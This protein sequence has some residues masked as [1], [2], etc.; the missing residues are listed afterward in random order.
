MAPS[1]DCRKP[2]WNGQKDDWK[3]IQPVV[4]LSKTVYQKEFHCLEG[5]VAIEA[6]ANVNQSYRNGT[7]CSTWLM[8]KLILEITFISARLKYRFPIP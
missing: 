3:G 8:G 5:D 1:W 4:N 7:I 2:C 6:R